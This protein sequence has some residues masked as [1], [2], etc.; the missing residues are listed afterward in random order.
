MNKTTA[1]ENLVESP[2][3]LPLL[4]RDLS[5]RAFLGNSLLAGG[6]LSLLDI[7]RRVSC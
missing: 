7:R 3:R 6:L 2:S 1:S 5:R 4:G